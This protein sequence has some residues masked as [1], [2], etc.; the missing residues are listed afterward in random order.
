M[1]RAVMMAGF[2]VSRLGPR[3]VWN[4]PQHRKNMIKAG[5]HEIAYVLPSAYGISP[6][7]AIPVSLQ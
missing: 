7:D 4:T 6:T 2:I 3:H 1:G 5:S